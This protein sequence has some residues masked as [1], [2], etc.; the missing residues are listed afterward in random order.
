MDDSVERLKTEAK[1]RG[2]PVGGTKRQVLLRLLSDI[3]NS[4]ALLD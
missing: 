4:D 2:V 3:S 1:R